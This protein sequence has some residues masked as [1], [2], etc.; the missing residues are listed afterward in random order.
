MNTTDLATPRLRACLVALCGTVCVTAALAGCEFIQDNP[1]AAK[2]TVIGAAGGAGT[3]AAIGAVVDGKKG[4]GKGAAIG[5]VVGAIGGGLIGTY[6]DRQADEMESVLAAQDRLNRE[7]DKLEVVM[8]SDVM[9]E[10]GQA[11]LQPGARDK[12]AHLAQVLNRYPETQVDVIGH[13]DDRG[14]AA[15]NEDLS[16]RRAEAVANALIANGVSASRIHASGEGA[17]RPLASNAT[18]AGRATNRRVEVEVVPNGSLRERA[19]AQ[20]GEPR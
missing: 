18:I 4:A 16:E 5:A 12:L 19:A 3:G 14:S 10:S 9:F 7:P 13:T 17:T 1:R 15:L 20:P 2:G 8:A 6:M 11:T